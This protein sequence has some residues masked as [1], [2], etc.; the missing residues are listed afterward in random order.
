VD[1]ECTH[2]ETKNTAII[3]SPL[4]LFRNCNVNPKEYQNDIIVKEQYYIEGNSGLKLKDLLP[5]K[6]TAE[7]KTVQK[8]TTKVQQ[9]YAILE[10]TKKNQQISLHPT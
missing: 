4:F 3:C 8:N 1:L 6:W 10:N 7:S 5:D 9:L 2:I